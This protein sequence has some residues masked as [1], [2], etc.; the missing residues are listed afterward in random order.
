MV[1]EDRG[2]APMP[3]RLRIQTTGAGT[4]DR[5]IPVAAWLGGRTTA[6]LALPASVGRVTRVEIDPDHVFPDA[7]RSNDVWPAGG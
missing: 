6:E 3:V 1:V 4:L 7:D 5:G 2:W